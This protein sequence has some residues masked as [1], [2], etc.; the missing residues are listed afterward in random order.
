MTYVVAVTWVAHPGEEAEVERCIRELVALSRA[1]PGVLTY[2]AH[3]DPSDPRVFY[4]YEQYADEAA[5]DAHLASP[6][7]QAI[8][9]GDALPRLEAR[10][11]GVYVPFDP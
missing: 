4:L 10:V 2:Q 1:E 8:G 9:F 6:H 11:R 3:R 5:Y 7:V